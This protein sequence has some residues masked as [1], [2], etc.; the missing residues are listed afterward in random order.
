MVWTAECREPLEQRVCGQE[1]TRSPTHHAGVPERVTD[2]QVAVIG[3]NCVEETLGAPQ[4]VEEGELGHAAVKGDLSASW[5]DRGHQ[6]FGHSDCREPHVNE[7]QVGQAVVHGGVEVGI[8][9]DHQQ[10][11]EV[12]PPQ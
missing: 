11:E 1:G 8:R 6:H 2:G 12:P 10:D 9:L 4:E 3:H 5:G 7:G